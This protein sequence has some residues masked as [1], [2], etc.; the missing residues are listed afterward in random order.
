VGRE[1][2]PVAFGATFTR[3]LLVIITLLSAAGIE[4]AAAYGDAPTL[5]WWMLAVPGYTLLYLWL[6]N[7]R[8]VTRE[9]LLEALID[10]K[11]Y[12]AGILAFVW[13]HLQNF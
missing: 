2:I 4:I 8:I 3:I 5:A 1:T 6:Y 7:R 10:T 13:W 12:I 11:F 9:V